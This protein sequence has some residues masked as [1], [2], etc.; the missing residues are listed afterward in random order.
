MS[1]VNAK[2]IMYPALKGGYAIGAF[3]VT[4]LVQFEA[5]IDAA[6][7]KKAPVIVQTSV[8]PSQFH[9]PALMVA[10]YRCRSACT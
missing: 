5:V 3:N 6:V 8:K 2:E 1:I 9:T 4:D 10:I 7:E